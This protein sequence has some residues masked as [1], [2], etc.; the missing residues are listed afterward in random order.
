MLSCYV[1]MA[2]VRIAKGLSSHQPSAVETSGLVSGLARAVAQDP[3]A[4]AFDRE[5]ATADGD[6]GAPLA[7]KWLQALG[8]YQC[9]AG[10]GPLRRFLGKPRRQA[11]HLRL[12]ALAQGQGGPVGMDQP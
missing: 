12:G 11:H 3:E 5:A 1:V 10:A 4:G 9:L 2:G 6:A 8:L 7:F